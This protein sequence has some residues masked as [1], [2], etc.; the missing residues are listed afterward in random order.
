MKNRKMKYSIF[1][2]GMILLNYSCGKDLDVTSSVTNTFSSMPQVSGPVSE[3]ALTRKLPPGKLISSLASTGQN[4]NELTFSGGESLQFCENAN[5][6]KGLLAEASNPDKILCYIGQME[7]LGMLS[8]ISNLSDGEYHYLH[9]ANM[10]DDSG[11]GNA[12][13]RIKFRISKDVDGNIEDFKMFSC[14]AGTSDSPVQ[15]E[16]ISQEF[17]GSAATIVAKYSDSRV[18][19]AETY[20]YGSDTNVSGTYNFGLG[21]WTSSKTINGRKVFSSTGGIAS[22]YAMKIEGTEYSD[23][24]E[25]KVSMDGNW[26][27]N[28]FTNYF[29]TA[30]Q[31]IRGD[32]EAVSSLALGDGATSYVMT[33]DDHGNGVGVDYSSTNTTAWT[34][35]DKMSS[36]Y[37]T[38]DFKTYVD[39]GTV[40]SVAPS[41]TAITFPGDEGWDCSLPSGESWVDI[42]FNDTPSAMDQIQ[43]CDE[44]Y[45]NQEWVQCPY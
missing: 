6:L 10:G 29:Y 8:A 34:G 9:F 41:T 25:A 24:F 2:I 44:D 28:Y 22:S 36:S 14:F 43:S 20:S 4:I 40:P 12:R 18:E 19:G 13:P 1:S 42:D 5:N 3:S 26:G 45:V 35:D 38:S 27:N 11:G 37:A 23:Y 16:Y 17:V 39:A 7:G 31:I 15:S 32:S 21:R 30:M 33:Y